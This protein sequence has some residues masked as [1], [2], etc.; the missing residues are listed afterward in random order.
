MVVDDEKNI[1]TFVM[2]APESHGMNVVSYTDPNLALQ[3]FADVSKSFDVF[4]SDLRM[5]ELTGFQM[6]RKVKELHP[7]IKFAN[8]SHYPNS[9]G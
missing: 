7:R 6:A 4:V 3:H 1:L 5:A 9:Y 2:K 8:P